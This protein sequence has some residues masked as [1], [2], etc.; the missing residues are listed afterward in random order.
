MSPS[1]S[2]N[3]INLKLSLLQNKKNHK[4]LMVF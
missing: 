3:T 2:S 4:I 1:S